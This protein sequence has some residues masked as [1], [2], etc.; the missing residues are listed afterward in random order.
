MQSYIE[1]LYKE[2]RQQE[3]YLKREDIRNATKSNEL[4]FR[5]ISIILMG[6]HEQEKNEKKSKKPL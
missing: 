1:Q 4:M 2:L 3:K 6:L 5:I